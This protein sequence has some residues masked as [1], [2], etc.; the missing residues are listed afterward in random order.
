MPEKPLVGIVMGSDTD[1]P[2]MTETAATLKKFH[3]PFEIEIKIFLP[4]IR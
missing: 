1:L 3:I 2:V 4:D